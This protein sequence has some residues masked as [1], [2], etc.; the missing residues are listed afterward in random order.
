MGNNTFG[1]STK[2]QTTTNNLRFP[3]QYADSEIGLNQNYFRDYVP[4]LG[5]SVAS[6]PISLTGGL[7]TFIYS[8][9]S[10]VNFLDIYGLCEIKYLPWVKGNPEFYG[11]E[12]LLGRS[13]KRI[14]LSEEFLFHLVC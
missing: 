9:S 7:N 10:P 6:Y 8:L 4:N 13:S 14:L 5:R 2:M 3:G 1:E 12:N 11:R